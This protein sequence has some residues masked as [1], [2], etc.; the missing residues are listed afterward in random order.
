MAVRILILH[1]QRLLREGLRAIL[2]VHGDLH[3]VADT[4][5]P[6]AAAA[7]IGETAPDVLVLDLC[8]IAD[9]ARVS[10][11]PPLVALGE[12]GDR[13]RIARALQTGVA[14]LVSKSDSPE[15]VVAAIRAA[16]AGQI[17][18]TPRLSRLAFAARPG[19]P[20]DALT[21]LTGRE[22][23][24]FMLVV[25]G[26]STAKIARQLDV[27]P[28]TIETHRSHPSRKLGAHSA[29]DLVRFA[30]RHGLLPS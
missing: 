9:V 3:V 25:R 30:A 4:A 16:A 6:A 26:L 19:A 20:E 24:I 17:Y 27:S 1:E 28:R 21:A 14:A 29:A 7:L 2:R 8:G 11:P 18:I 22:R 15:E 5:D 10:R 23:E 13:P 12:D